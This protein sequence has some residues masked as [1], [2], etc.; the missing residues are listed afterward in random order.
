M[1]N[2]FCGLAVCVF[3]K[4]FFAML[5]IPIYMNTTEIFLRTTH[6]YGDGDTG[7]LYL[8]TNSIIFNNLE[9]FNVL[10]CCITHPT[11]L[12]LYLEEVKTK[13]NVSN[14]IGF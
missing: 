2:Y 7:N 13:Y 4:G 9:N 6:Y 12:V 5:V 10:R 11:S 8:V 1:E 14:F 3:A